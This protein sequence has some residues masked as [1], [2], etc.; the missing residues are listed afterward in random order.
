M[1]TKKHENIG[2]KEKRRTKKHMDVPKIAVPNCTG[3][4]Q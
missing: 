1:A 4:H 3:F 2:T